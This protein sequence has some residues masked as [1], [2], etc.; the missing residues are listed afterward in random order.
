MYDSPQ[1]DYGYD[2]SDYQNVYAP[3]G[4]VADMDLLIKECHSRDIKL[5]LDLVINH[6]SD[7]HKWFQESKSSKTNEKADWYYWKDPKIVDGKRHPPN[8]WRATFGGSAWDYVPERD[9]YYV[10]L[11]FVSLNC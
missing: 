2:I 11:S 10:R 6:T 3:F 9:Q 8:N 4:T 1:V 7:Q 5:L